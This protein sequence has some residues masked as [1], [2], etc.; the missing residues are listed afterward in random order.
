MVCKCCG[1][2]TSKVLSTASNR[3]F[4]E[5]STW[6][7]CPVQFH[8]KLNYKLVENVASKIHWW[9]TYRGGGGCP[10]ITANNDQKVFANSN[11]RNAAPVRIINDLTRDMSNSQ[12]SES[13]GAAREVFQRIFNQLLNTKLK[14]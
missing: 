5:L 8:K 11:A 14:Y 1:P 2:N 7:G 13:L 6:A 12:P 10:A 4:K 9:K 3:C